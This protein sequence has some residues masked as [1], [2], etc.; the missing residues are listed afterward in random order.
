VTNVSTVAAVAVAIAA[1]AGAAVGWTRPDAAVQP[2]A[3][4][5]RIVDVRPL[6]T[7]DASVRDLITHTFAV[8]VAIRGWTLLPYRPGATAR[9]N[10]TRAGH[11]RLYVDGSLLGDMFGSSTVSYTGYLAPGTHW[12]A[13]ELSNA[14]RTSLFPAVWSEPVIVRVPRTVRCWQTGWRG[15][16]E[17]GTP[18][19]SCGA[20]IRPKPSPGKDGS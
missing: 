9:H 20:A 15:T 19:F 14:D 1:A 3:P 18:T 10:R 8:R 6:R 5:I 12:L 17:T 2:P 13:A 7:S 11:W 4:S 16:P